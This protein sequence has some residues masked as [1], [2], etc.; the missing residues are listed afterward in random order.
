MPK[1]YSVK[2]DEALCKAC[3]ICRHACPRGVWPLQVAQ[4]EACIGCQRCELFCPELAISVTP[5]DE[6]VTEPP[7]PQPAA[8]SIAPDYGGW[9]TA[10][11]TLPAGVHFLS[12]N[13]ACAEGAIAAGCRFYGGYPITP[14]SEIMV[15]MAHRLPEIGGAFVQMEDEIASLSAVIGASWAG[16][17]SMT[18]TSG[19]GFSLMMEN[20]GYAVMTETPCVIVDVQR[21]GPST[22]QASR[23]AQGDVMQARW[24]T[25]GGPEIIGLAPWSAQE[26]YDLTI[27]AFNLAE[28]FRV[29]V[30]VLADEVVGHLC[31]TITVEPAVRCF[32]R[33]RWPQDSPFGTDADDGVPPMPAL[34]EGARL[35]VTGSTH[36][37]TGVRR[38]TEPQAQE[39]LVR[40][41][42]RKLLAHRDEIDDW[43]A[44]FTADA[45]RLV[46]AYGSVARSALWAV[47]E[48]RRRGQRV[49]LLRL[50]SLWPFPD[51][52]VAR[53][54]PPS[55]P[56]TLRPCSGQALGGKEG[57]LPKG[58]ERGGE[59]IVPEMNLGQVAREVERCVA[60][61]VT[62]LSQTDGEII[63][64]RRIL[65]YLLE[66]RWER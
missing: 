20:L 38:T 64:P 58:G 21:A 6:R 17:K 46:V 47:Q 3:A 34:G 57:G 1:T 9:T 51:E 8:P 13:E 32:N 41:L 65:R 11:G 48:A 31:E 24:G 10:P 62:C 56:P 25:H 50:K 54:A 15:R 60:A 52:I 39:R 14:S 44:H 18:A 2:L 53:Y 29:P 42:S 30:V 16:S 36:D 63:D 66:G 61:P 43:E 49:G 59:V 26:M 4:P 45:E 27:R 23:P 33:V 55:S 5:A 22:G 28:R 19:P 35:L 12:G 37:A 7:V 40:R